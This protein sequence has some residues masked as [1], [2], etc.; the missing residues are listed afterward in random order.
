M[1]GHRQGHS[2]DLATNEPAGGFDAAWFGR[3]FLPVCG[4]G[5]GSLGPG[6]NQAVCQEMTVPAATY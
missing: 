6:G 2:G 3:C 1:H 4:L 5:A